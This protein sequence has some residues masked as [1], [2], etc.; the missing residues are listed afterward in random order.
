MSEES[1]AAGNG[2]RSE[3]GSADTAHASRMNLDG[4]GKQGAAA[5][6][7]ELWSR[8]G[9]VGDI[10][11]VERPHPTFGYTAVSGPH[12]PHRLAVADLDLPDR[13]DPSALPVPFM[14]SVSG[15]VLSASARRLPAPWA[16]RNVEADE[17]HFVQGG[18]LDYVTDFGTISV[19]PGDFL[20][21]PRATTYRVE[22]KSG[23]TLT[24]IIETPEAAKL[25]PPAPFGM[26]NLAASVKRPDP[27]RSSSQQ[28]ETT[29]LVK[30]FD[31]ATLFTKP[32]DPMAIRRHLGGTI[33]VW[34]VSLK[35]I[36]P[37]TYVPHG[38]PP[39][40]FV[41]TP[42]MDVLLYTLS[43]RPGARP[44]LH[45]NADYD[46]VIF[47]AGGDDWGKVSEPGTLT[48][49]PKGVTHW[50]PREDTGGHLAWLL[51]VGGTLRF[52]SAG[53]DAADLMETGEYGRHPA[54]RRP[55]RTPGTAP[56]GNA[57]ARAAVPS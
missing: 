41:N 23:Q 11:V 24:V 17:I 46:E 42:S 57:A 15:V 47:Y 16:V 53:L 19:E 29:L 2:A 35:D 8:Q 26:I 32:G 28:G 25:N 55:A 37:V 1:T 49:V 45:H 3:N 5:P 31:G 6:N 56:A 27:A 22:P 21:L 20:H 9:F 34:K 30:S 40:H 12:A 51:E 36:S 54:S 39:S 14:R 48:W 33:P 52:T 4:H 10:C 44:P 7:V 50:G 38:G 13:D 43:A 18:Q